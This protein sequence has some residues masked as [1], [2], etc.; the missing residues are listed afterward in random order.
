MGHASLPPLGRS[1]VVT[2]GLGFRLEAVPGPL[3]LI[4]L[5]TE[6]ADLRGGPSASSWRR[7]SALVQC[8]GNGLQRRCAT[9]LQRG[10]DRSEFGSASF[11]PL[12]THA[13]ACLAPLACEA[14]DPG[15]HAAT[16]Y[17]SHGKATSRPTLNVSLCHIASRPG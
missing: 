11:G 5:R 10:D 15:F 1:A 2:G 6:A 4:C 9:C 17:I 12:L 16:L 14:I 7:N 3:P 8:I 13:D